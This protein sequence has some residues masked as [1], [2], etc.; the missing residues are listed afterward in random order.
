[1]SEPYTSGITATAARV[2]P[3]AGVRAVSGAVIAQITSTS[4]T[5][6]AGIAIA[7]A[8]SSETGL[9]IVPISCAPRPCRR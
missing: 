7:A 5:A 2:F 3:Q 8:M 9:P 1:M 6:I 4:V